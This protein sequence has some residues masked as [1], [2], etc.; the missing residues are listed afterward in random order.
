MNFSAYKSS[1]DEQQSLS[2]RD[3]EGVS[4]NERESY[5]DERVSCN[6]RE[7]IDEGESCWIDIESVSEVDSDDEW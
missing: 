7:N 3:D 4:C 5:V 6:E 1:E 2:E